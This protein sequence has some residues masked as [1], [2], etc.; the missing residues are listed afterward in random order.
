MCNCVYD[1]FY[2]LWVGYVLLFFFCD[3]GGG[4][5]DCVCFKWWYC[6]EIIFL[7]KWCCIWQNFLDSSWLI[8]L[9]G[10]NSQAQ[11][12]SVLSSKMSWKGDVS[13]EWLIVC[14]ELVQSM[15]Q[16]EG[17]PLVEGLH[18]LELFMCLTILGWSLFSTE[19]PSIMS[20]SYVSMLVVGECCGWRT[21]RSK[22]SSLEGL[23]LS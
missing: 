5:K 7:I 17:F 21:C 10:T 8:W 23:S 1:F 2:C 14:G 18:I 22:Y 20:C 3:F 19:L 16:V 12:Q 13:Q 9:N 11:I 4:E 15:R 6:Q